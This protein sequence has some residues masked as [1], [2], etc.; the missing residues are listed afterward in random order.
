MSSAVQRIRYDTWSAYKADLLKEFYADGLFE[1][2]RY[3]YRG[4]GSDNWQ[5]ETTFDRE[6]RDLGGDARATLWRDLV[7][8]FREACR[9]AGFPADVLS[10]E[11]RLLAIGQHYGLPT[12]LL[13]WTTSPYTAA[14]FAFRR[15]LRMTPDLSDRAAIWVLDARSTIWGADFGVEMILPSRL[16]DDRLRNQ[17]GCFTY[18]RTPQTNLV[19]FVEA[20]QP[21]KPVLSQISIPVSAAREAVPDLEAMGVHAGHLFPDSTGLAEAAT[22]RATYKNLAAIRDSTSLLSARRR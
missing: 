6:F 16:D 19:S 13:D 8:M 5:L 11:G 7:A 21:E 4:M 17:G 22:L 18:S 2:G 20:M 1:H 14:F 10:D 12:R 3:I 15:G 9:N